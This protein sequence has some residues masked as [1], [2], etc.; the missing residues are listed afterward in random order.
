MALIGKVQKGQLITADMMN[1]IIDSIR[2]CQLQSVVGGVFKRGVGGTTITLKAGQQQGQEQTLCPFTPTATA[3]TSG[4]DVTFQVGTINGVLP[5][6]ILDKL[7][8][9]STSQNNYFYIKCTTDGKII[10]E[11]VIESDTTLRTPVQPTADTAPEEFDILIGY[12]TTAGLTQRIIACGN[13]SAKIAPSIQE[14][15]E[16]YVA[17]ARNYTQYYNWIFS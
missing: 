1:N 10:T 12:M 13:L 6:N 7:S 15:S 2:E 8:N 14:D 4:Y 16:T 3:T 5:T 17:G 11:A 9:V